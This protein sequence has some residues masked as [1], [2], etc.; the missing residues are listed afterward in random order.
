MQ[1]WQHNAKFRLW[2]AQ[3]PFNSENGNVVTYIL[4]L[5]KYIHIQRRDDK[6]QSSQGLI[7]ETET[8]RRNPSAGT[9]DGAVTLEEVDAV[10]S[11]AFSEL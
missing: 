2:R 4:V 7:S 10:H 6:N 9:D 11:G 1:L 8:F 3:T 5:F